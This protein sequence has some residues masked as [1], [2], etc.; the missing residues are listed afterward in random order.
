MTKFESI[1]GLA[2]GV[3][4]GSTSL[5]AL[6]AVGSLLYS[7][8]VDEPAS[9]PEATAEAAP[10]QTAS[11]TAPAPA[12]AQVAALDPEAGAKVFQKCAACHT[13][14]QG[15]AARTG[16]NLWNIVARPVAS[17]AGFSYSEAMLAQANEV[18]SPE[19]LDQYLTK[20]KDM[21]PG[22]TMAF[23]GLSKP[24]DRH[25]LI[26]WL[27]G[28]NDAPIAPGDLPFAQSDAVASEAPAATEA[29]AAE[30]PEIAQIPFTNPP[31][32][33]A[34]Q[35][36]EIAARVAA[37]EAEVEGLSYDEARYH[38][39]HFP[40]NI[41]TASN[42]ECLVCHQEINDAKPRAESPAGVQAETSLAW[43][44]TLDT[45]SGPQADLHW[46]HLQSDFAQE[47]M[48]LQ[49]NFCHQGNDPR[50]ESPD[51]MPGRPFFSASASPEFTNRKM[52][53]PETT[54]LRCHG[55]MPD[56]V[57]IMGLGGPW[58]EVRGDMEDPTDPATANGCLSCHGELF[59]TNRH[60]VTYLNAANIEELAKEVS[61]DTCYGCH[62][63]RAWYRI[64][65]PY[66]RHP[67]PGMDPETPAWAADRPTASDE[68]YRLPETAE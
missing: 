10:S 41:E 22:T 26:A 11:A 48:N 65:Y 43:Y 63:G 50:E 46:R 23:A 31:A 61:S 47:V 39:I 45:Y 57:E 40:K 67:W 60:N 68:K 32:P 28:Q 17:A 58:H 52:V 18:W 4:L 35:E 25:N 1:L 12:E 13:A 42:A 44:Q 30:A 3:L 21:V 6:N 37:L 36:A 19:R 66:A 24:A 51:M 7:I 29:P 16:P 55:A 8:S 20:P 14:D 34:E 27:A 2:F 64:S 15:G 54:C 5:V 38:P 49:C 9:A 56:P 59:R 53:N 33:S 62:G